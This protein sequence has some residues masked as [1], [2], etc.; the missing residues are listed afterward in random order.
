MRALTNDQQRIYDWID[1][2]LWT[3]WDPVGVND[4]TDWRDEYR[5][6]VNGVFSLIIHGAD[7]ERIAIRLFEIEKQMGFDGNKEKCLRIA[8][9]ISKPAET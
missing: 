1:E 3:E 7:R 9:I 5:S 6:Y 2:I 4:D 8:D